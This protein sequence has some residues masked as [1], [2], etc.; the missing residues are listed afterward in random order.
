M[1]ATDGH[2]GTI[3]DILVIAKGLAS[4]YPLSAIVSRQELTS[5]QPAGSMG[6]TYTGNAVSCA[7]A[8][9]TIEVIKEENL[10]QN[11]KDRGQQ[12]MKGLL[13]MKKSGKYPIRDVRGLGLMI[14]VEFDKAVPYGTSSKV[15]AACLKHG[16][17]LL[18]TSV[19]ETV[20]FIP[21]L[22]VSAE[23][24]DLALDTFQKALNELFM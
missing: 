19:Y 10:I 21:S 23:E 7:A 11:T 16:M 12:L 20:R 18:T 14:G 3:P 8:L 15:S 17:L 24:I 5:K 9:A 1:F 22:N 4:G 6:G 13:A 2:Y